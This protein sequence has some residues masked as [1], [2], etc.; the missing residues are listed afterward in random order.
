MAAYRLTKCAAIWGYCLMLESTATD[1]LCYQ[2]SALSISGHFAGCTSWISFLSLTCLPANQT[3]V[4]DARVFCLQNLKSKSAR[5]QISVNYTLLF[6]HLCVAKLCLVPQ[7]EHVIICSA[8]IAG[9][10]DDHA[11]RCTCRSTHILSCI[12]SSSALISRLKCILHCSLLC[13]Y[14]CIYLPTAFSFT[15]SSIH[16]LGAFFRGVLE[17][18]GVICQ[19]I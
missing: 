10:T 12:F 16:T 9:F 5:H 15:A 7:C 3:R 19:A 11:P 6:T 17:A 18:G 13:T 4:S 2:G 1:L 14:A 8:V